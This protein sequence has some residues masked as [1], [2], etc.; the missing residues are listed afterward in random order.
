MVSDERI[1]RHVPESLKDQKQR[2]WGFLRRYLT[3]NAY[4]VNESDYYP[5][6]LFGEAARW[7][8]RIPANPSAMSDSMPRCMRS[9]PAAC[10]WRIRVIMVTIQTVVAA[11]SRIEAPAP[12]EAM[13]SPAS[14]GPM[15][16]P[17]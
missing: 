14:T 10:G 11:N 13:T 17:T 7:V 5:A 12:W 6:R 4:R 8:E 16:A 9:R 15:N 3:N 1:A 2:L